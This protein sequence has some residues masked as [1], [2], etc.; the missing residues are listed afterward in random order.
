MDSGAL[1]NSFAGTSHV[2]THA[3]LGIGV[4]SG[5]EALGSINVT[6][7]TYPRNLEG[8]I[9]TIDEKSAARVGGVAVNEI[10]QLS[11]RDG[12]RGALPLEY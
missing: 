2:D 1:E 7:L 12:R 4:S 6:M 5:S 8:S 9:T 3:T 11:A 10:Q